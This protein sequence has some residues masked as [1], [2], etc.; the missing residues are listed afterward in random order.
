MA[1]VRSTAH[2]RSDAPMQEAKGAAVEMGAFD[3]TCDSARSVE[4]FGPVHASDAGSQSNAKVIPMKAHVV[5]TR[6]LDGHCEP[7][8]RFDRAR[9]FHRRRLP[10]TGGGK[11]S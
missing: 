11:C 10:C 9:I 8:S 2:S 5:T 6:P 3:E 7:Y 1:H 4:R